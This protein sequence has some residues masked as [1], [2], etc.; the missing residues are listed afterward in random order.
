MKE[1]YRKGIAKPFWPRWAT[2]PSPGISRPASKQT[3]AS[4]G[5]PHLGGNGIRMID[6]ARQVCGSWPLAAS[7]FAKYAGLSP[8]RNTLIC[9]AGLLASPHPTRQYFLGLLRN[10]ISLFMMDVN[11]QYAIGR[12]A[13]QRGAGHGYWT[14]RKPSSQSIAWWTLWAVGFGLAD[15]EPKLSSWAERRPRRVPRR[16]P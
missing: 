3:T 8:L 16:P 9:P 4:T 10:A 13:M 15:G 5:W 1:P 11:G 12:N 14:L 7:L 2:G 6:L